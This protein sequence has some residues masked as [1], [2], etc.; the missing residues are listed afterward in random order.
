MLPLINYHRDDD[1]DDFLYGEPSQ[2]KL[3]PPSGKML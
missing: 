2:V 3:Q 1:D